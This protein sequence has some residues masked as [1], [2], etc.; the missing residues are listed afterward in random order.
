MLDGVVVGVNGQITLP[1]IIFFLE[2]R[3]ILISRIFGDFGTWLILM[4]TRVLVV[5]LIGLLF[6]TLDSISGLGTFFE[7]GCFIMKFI[8]AMTQGFSK[9]SS[10]HCLCQAIRKLSPCMNP[11]EINPFPEYFLY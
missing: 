2:N 10:F 11:T 7:G 3:K 1:K 9:E 6:Q 8:K 4:F 5:V